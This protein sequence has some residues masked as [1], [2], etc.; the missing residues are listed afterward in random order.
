MGYSPTLGR[1]LERD[2]DEYVD[3]LN[4]YQFVR[5]DPVAL[6]DP[7]GLAAEPVTRP[8]SGPSTQPSTKP[9]TYPIND[10]GGAGKQ[11]TATIS[12]AGA[13]LCDKTKK[14]TIQVT[15]RYKLIDA[16]GE[17]PS[18][19]GS[20]LVNGQKVNIAAVPDTEDKEFTA[21]SSIAVAADDK[22]QSGR[23]YVAAVYNKMKGDQQTGVLHAWTIN[24]KYDCSCGTAG[25][26]QTD[27]KFDED[28]NGRLPDKDPG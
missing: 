5:D 23:I 25:P 13:G 15:V 26:L 27:I 28:V 8:S 3:G 16:L 24:W 7:Y 17:A 9:S 11:G 6:R 1:F 4:P 2:R 20:L 18:R 19:A 10:P 14:G 12:V 21:T 22:G